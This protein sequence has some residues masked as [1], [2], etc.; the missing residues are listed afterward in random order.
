M[1]RN[2]LA[3]IAALK[4]E[5]ADFRCAVF[6]STHGGYIEATDRNL[7]TPFETIPHDRDWW[8]AAAIKIHDKIIP[9]QD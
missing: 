3:V 8:T 5:M 4:S 9:L 6:C 2:R 7:T 1:T